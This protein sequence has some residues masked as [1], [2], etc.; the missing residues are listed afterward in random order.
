MYGQGQEILA[1][2]EEGGGAIEPTEEDKEGG[3][4]GFVSYRYMCIGTQVYCALT[5]SYI[6]HQQKM[7]EN[8]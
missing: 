5:W 3:A 7:L 4:M 8:R 2:G 6:L 1:E